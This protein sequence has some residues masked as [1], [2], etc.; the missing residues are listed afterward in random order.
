MS[1][2]PAAVFEMPST[3]TPASWAIGSDCTAA[4]DSVGPMIRLTPSATNWSK[5]VMPWRGSVWSSSMRRS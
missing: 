5:S 4:L 1:V 2:M 3:G